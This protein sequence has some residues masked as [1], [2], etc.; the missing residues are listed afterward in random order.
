MTVLLGVASSP[1][2]WAQTDPAKAAYLRYCSACHGE[3]GKGDG[4]VSHLM[5]PKPTDLTRLAKDN[6][7]EFPFMYIVHVIDG[8]ETVRAHGDSDMPVWG[9]LFKAQDGMTPNQHAEVRGRVMMITEHL[10]TIQEK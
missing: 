3:G 10:S 7:G 2:S 4:V 6:E 9:D 1:A 8:R 5:R